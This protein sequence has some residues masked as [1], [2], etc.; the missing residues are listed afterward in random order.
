MA[1]FAR[2]WLPVAI[3]ACVGV[4]TLGA[5]TATGYC[6][7]REPI[8][9]PDTQYQPVD[10]AQHRWLGDRR[11]RHRFCRLSRKLPR[12]QWRLTSSRRNR[13]RSRTHSEPS[14][15]APLRR[16][17]LRKTAR[18]SSSRTISGRCASASSATR[19]GLLTGYYEPII[20]GSRVPTGEFT[21]PLYRR[22]PNLAIAG[23][24]K[25]RRRLSQQRREGRPACR[26]PQARALLRS[27]PDRGRCA[28]R[29]ASGN[30]LCAQ[31]GRC[32]VR[33]DPRLG[34]HQA[35][36]RHH[37]AGQLRLA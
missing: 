28:R 27:R 22:P 1:T 30:L 20:D 18:A 31:P 8:K 16:F 10:W 21:A 29:L 35:R 34:A 24:R 19:E 2:A 7:E 15:C 13:R 4:A 11:S 9:L 33:A 5:G 37:S 23:R 6:A 12:A 36:R 25:A 14:A 32:A 3:V 17:R 26:P